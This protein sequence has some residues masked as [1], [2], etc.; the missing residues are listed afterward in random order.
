MFRSE[1]LERT[2][3]HYSCVLSY[4]YASTSA[5]AFSESIDWR[6]FVKGPVAAENC[7]RQVGTSRSLYRHLWPRLRMANYTGFLWE[8]AIDWPGPI[9]LSRIPTNDRI[10]HASSDAIVRFAPPDPTELAGGHDG[11]T[12]IGLQNS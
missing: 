8:N 1:A 11:I 9:D 5:D 6:S 2:R 12:A 10:R 7:G 4:A 3:L